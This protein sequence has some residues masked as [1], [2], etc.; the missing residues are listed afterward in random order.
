MANVYKF[1][2]VLVFF[3]RRQNSVYI[4]IL[5]MAMARSN[6][7]GGIALILDRRKCQMVGGMNDEMV[8]DTEQKRMKPMKQ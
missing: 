5:L 4:V 2:D 7:G 8:C 3:I 1:T 6:V